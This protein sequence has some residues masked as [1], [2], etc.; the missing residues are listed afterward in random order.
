M[1]WTDRLGIRIGDIF[2]DT[3]VID[4]KVVTKVE[5]I[6]THAFPLTPVPPGS[7]ATRGFGS[8][9]RAA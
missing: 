1:V 8:A 3:Q 9:A 6:A 2:A 4:G 5:V 7:S